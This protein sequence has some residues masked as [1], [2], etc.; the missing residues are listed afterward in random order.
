MANRAG[1]FVADQNNIGNSRHHPVEQRHRQADRTGRPDDILA[2]V[3]IKLVGDQGFDL[4]AIFG[5]G[6]Q[7]HDKFVIATL[8]K[9]LARVDRVDHR[10]NPV[11]GRQHR[12]DQR[13]VG[14]A[15]AGADIGQRP[16]GGVPQF[17][18]S[19]QI[20]KA[21]AALHRM[22]KTENGIEPLAIGGIGLPRN[23]L[24]LHRL[25]HL[26]RLSNEFCQ[27]IVHIT[28]P[29]IYSGDRWHRDG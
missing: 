18:Y 24:T 27:Q 10:D 5:V 23:Q 16:F 9:G 19:R 14:R 17:L 11:D 28:P 20:E 25:E 22:D 8:G 3:V 4:A 6:L 12:I 13:A 1:Q 21:A 2:A 29:R 7:R 15:L 26:A